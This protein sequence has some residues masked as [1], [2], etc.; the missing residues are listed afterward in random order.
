[1][2]R[3]TL[4]GYAAFVAALAVVWAIQ[5]WAVPWVDMY[6]TSVVVRVGINMLA[7]VGLSL[8]LGITGQFSLG[9]RKSVV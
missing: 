5:I 4:F 8:V 6:L 1:M 2:P 3:A 9:D 7:A